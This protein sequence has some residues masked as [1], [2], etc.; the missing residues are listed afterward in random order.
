MQDVGAEA[1][2]LLTQAWIEM[3]VMVP[4]EPHRLDHE[5][6][7]LDEASFQLEDTD[8]TLVP[9]WRYDSEEFDAGQAR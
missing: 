8:P 1:G 6:I 4:V 3:D 7:A 2:D 5:L 9:G